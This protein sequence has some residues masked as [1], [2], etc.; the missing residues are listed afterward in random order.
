MVT[1]PSYFELPAE[2]QEPEMNVLHFAPIL[3]ILALPLL[4]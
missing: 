3:E 2:L 4:Q 1:K